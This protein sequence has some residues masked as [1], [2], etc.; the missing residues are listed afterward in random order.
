ML[1]VSNFQHRSFQHWFKTDVNGFFVT[2]MAYLLLSFE[3][4]DMDAESQSDI[5]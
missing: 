1:K 5:A 2:V 3:N 4:R